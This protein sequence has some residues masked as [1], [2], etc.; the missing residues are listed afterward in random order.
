PEPGLARVRSAD[1]LDVGRQGGP[2]RADRLASP[3]P[4]PLIVD[5]ALRAGGDRTRASGGSGRS[6]RIS[7]GLFSPTR[8]SSERVDVVVGGRGAHWLASARRR[9]PVGGVDR[10]P[11]EAGRRSAL[12]RAD[13]RRFGRPWARRR[14]SRVGER[15]R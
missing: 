10:A 1:Q 12:A 4:N 13:T 7:G 9:T 15:P 14:R 5:S 8:A 6:L 3:L 2:Y 11:G